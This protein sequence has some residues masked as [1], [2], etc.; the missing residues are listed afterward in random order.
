MLFLFNW[1][2]TCFCLFL[3][4]SYRA[5]QAALVIYDVTNKKTFQNA[6]NWIREITQVKL[7]GGTGRILKTLP[8]FRIFFSWIIFLMRQNYPRDNC[9]GWI[10]VLSLKK[11]WRKFLHHAEISDQNLFCWDHL[12]YETKTCFHHSKIHDLQHTPKEEHFFLTKTLMLSNLGGVFW[13]L[14]PKDLL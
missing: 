6:Q 3:F 1:K 5:A 14:F 13:K 11:S 7:F 8:L 4:L 2:K 9:L 12:G 10:S